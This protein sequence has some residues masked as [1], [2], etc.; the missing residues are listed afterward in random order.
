MN[1][2]TKHIRTWI[3]VLSVFFL[4]VL[5]CIFWERFTSGP[6]EPLEAQ[7][8]YN[9]E[10]AV[11]RVQPSVVSL[12]AIKKEGL[13]TRISVIGCGLIVDSRGYLLTSATL[14]PDI[15]SL[16]VLDPKDNK[17]E[18]SVITTD[19]RTRLTLL[20][21]DTGNTTDSIRFEAAQLSDSGQ[22][23]K[24]DG[25]IVLGSRRTPSSWE[26]TTKTGR[27]T[28]QR[29]SLVVEPLAQTQKGAS[30]EGGKLKYRDLIQ[31]DVLLTSEN[32]GGPLVNLEGEVIGFGL[33]FVR[34]ANSSSFSYAVPVN[35]GKNFLARLPIPQWTDGPMEQV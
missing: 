12:W 5:L 33:P 14:T 26:L 32:A 8:V 9:P 28:K 11:A 19:K 4:V 17:Y 1:V 22:V 10:P 16:Y 24:G 25:V 21:A 29:Q 31:T 3:T 15:E 34:P 13:D 27:I 30:G 35:Q 6:V 2:R 20:K 18:A 7:L 23:R